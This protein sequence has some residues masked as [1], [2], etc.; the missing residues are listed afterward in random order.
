M[1]LKRRPRRNRRTASLREMIAESHLDPRTLVWPVF[2]LLEENK[3]EEI[4]TMPGQY[5]WGWKSAL[6]EMKKAEQLGIGSF[7]L[8]PVI[9]ETEK[10]ASASKAVEATHPFIQI[11]KELR[12]GLPDSIL[13]SDIALDPF[14]SD[15]HDGLVR[16]G[17]ILNDE[18]VEILC[19]MAVLH[20]STGVDFV[21][22]SDMM[23]GRVGAIREA[24]DAKGFQETGILAYSAKYAS[25]F[26]G[27]FRDAL[28]SAPRFG[29][30]KTYQMDSR[31]QREALLEAELD[32]QEGA[33]I[34]MVKPGLPY[35]DVISQLRQ[36]FNVPIAAYNVS[37]EYAMIKW[38]AKAG[39]IDE[40]KA[41]LEVLM[42]LRRAGA[43]LILTYHAL[44]AAI[45]LK[46]N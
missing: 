9:G 29:D 43:D 5:R 46:K 27:P 20:A 44:D 28:S 39:A 18:T 21:A 6:E 10:D 42:S 13:I 24:L 12:K 19:R 16:E 33:D 7:A 41:V 17:K 22:P 30:K 8:F 23:D 36:R 32:I 25:S 45:W 3:R 15:G 2:I 31:N 35:L 37:G 14:S 38:A 11:L 4:A 1:Q 40:K 26:Y 34:I